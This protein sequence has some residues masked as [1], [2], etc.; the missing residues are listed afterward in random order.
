MAIRYLTERMLKLED[1]TL[2][3]TGIK[4]GD[5]APLVITSGNP[6]RV[7]R[8]K[9]HLTD[10]KVFGAERGAVVITGK[11]KDTL[12]TLASTG[13][14]CPSLAMHVEELAF[15]GGKVFIRAG[16]CASLQEDIN[17][18]DLIIATGAVRDEGT[19]PYYAPDIYPAVADPDVVEALRRSAEACDVDYRIGIIRSTDSFYEGERKTEIIELWQRL[20]VLAFEM[21]SSALFTISNVL[22]LKSG[23]VLV[24]GSNLITQHSTYQGMDIE[25][26]QKGVQDMSLVALEAMRLLASKNIV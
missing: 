5:V 11:Y 17:L 18:G 14:G 23:S 2:P 26:Y 24:P 10:P 13:M 9:D 21:E 25:M 20:N 15:A 22:G 1:G 3:H 7:E 4:P 12:V 8:M 6:K 19:S 16:S